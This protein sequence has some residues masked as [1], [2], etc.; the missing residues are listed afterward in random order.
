VSW[1]RVAAAL[2]VPA[3]EILD[4]ESIPSLVDPQTPVEH[5]KDICGSIQNT[6]H[7]VLNLLNR[8]LNMIELL[9]A[10]ARCWR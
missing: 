2:Q 3:G 1:S 8:R 10:C 7:G 6:Q 5:L 4:K 9:T